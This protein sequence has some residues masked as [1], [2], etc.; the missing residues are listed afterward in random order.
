[1]A[2]VEVPFTPPLVAVLAAVDGLPTDV[3]VVQRMG[4]K[5]VLGDQRGVAEVVQKLHAYASLLAGEVGDR[6]RREL[7]YAGLAQRE[8]FRTPE[9]LVQHE[10]GSTAREASTLVRVGGMV[11]DAL[12]QEAAAADPTA[13][14]AVAGFVSR[15]PWLNA[16]GAAVN[17]GT[18]SVDAATAIRSGLGQPRADANGGGVSS[19][20]LGSAAATLLVEASGLNAD[21]LLQR[22]RDLRDDLD[23]AGIADRERVIHQER[24]FRRV[25]RPN[26][27]HRY[28]IDPDVESAAFWDDTYD[29]LTSPRR[30][31]ARFV[32]KADQDWAETIATDPRST[33]QYVHDSITQLLRIAV[34]AEF[35][36][37]ADTANSRRIIGS[38]TPAVR[39]LVNADALTS[40]TGHGR[41]EGCDIPVS[42][43]TVERIACTTGTV[44]IQFDPH[45]Q[46][47]NLGREQRLFTARQRI[48]LAARDGGCRWPDCDRPPSWTEAHHTRHWLRDAGKTNIADGILLCRHHHLL[49][50]NN[51]WEI[52]RENSDYWLIPPPD[53]DRAQTPRPMPSKSAALRDLQQLRDTG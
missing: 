12:R 17:A 4:D 51:H 53:I 6:S 33:E 32:D 38:R 35:A 36:D 7:G 16:V 37:P 48:A 43:E 24:S 50:H 49:L 2:I 39:V 21:R 25:R 29:K 14:P 26:G 30:G 27:V 52:V 5:M 19:E 34:D 47:M 18:L 9:A 8:G 22:A 23:A 31:G 3:G 1:M 13:D 45:G 15:E 11:H 20:D 41:I 10:T 46:V 44:P 42:I 40:R 28:I